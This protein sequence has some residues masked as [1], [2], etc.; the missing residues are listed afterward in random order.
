MIWMM[1]GGG[2]FWPGW[3]LMAL[4][5]P[6]VTVVSVEIATHLTSRRD[7]ALHA[8][9]SVVIALTATGVW[10]MTGTGYCW[11]IWVF[12]GLAIL[13]SAHAWLAP[14]LFR[15]QERIL[16]ERVASLTE[17]R[18]QVLALQAAELQRV[19]RD[20]H[21]GAQARLVALGLTL[22]M[23]DNI[24][25]DDPEE[26]HR[27]LAEG[28]N[29]LS[30]ALAELRSLVRG[31]M[32]PVLSERGLEG[33]V[34]AL[35]L[36]VPIPVAVNID[37]SAFRARPEVASAAY[38]VVAEALANV[39]KHSNAQTASITICVMDE[40]LLLE[41]TDD[42]AGGA[43]PEGGTGLRG[44]QRR[45][46]VLDGGLLLASPSGGPTVVTMTIPCAP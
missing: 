22:G 12:L 34:R 7:L 24:L 36:S 23:A 42:G 18:R 16:V 26:A 37:L 19:E 35:A 1:A 11:P 3:V 28:R 17:G 10:L 41:V 8:G 39:V 32:P 2:Y 25:D 20:L 30:E 46:E 4:A 21:D 15:D 9:F 6:I 43:V 45:L 33:A 40:L 13:F 29:S 14:F 5:L 31:I 38:F 44:I 27:L